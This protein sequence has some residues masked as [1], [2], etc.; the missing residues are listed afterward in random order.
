MK[1]TSGA[2]TSSGLATAVGCATPPTSWTLRK[3]RRDDPGRGLDLG[4]PSA[5][6]ATR[7]GTIGA[8]RPPLTVAV[9]QPPCVP[10]DVAANALAHP[11]AVREAKARV[12]VFPELSLTGYELD[13][14]AVSLADDALA[15]LAEACKAARS[16]ALVGA[17][18]SDSDGREYIAMLRIDAGGA[19]LA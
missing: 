18:V 3:H 11:E 17:P 7:C 15:P 10:R 16:V 2:T 6:P 1:T 9:A 13:A 8:L 12:V 14:V 4:G 5:C 19:A